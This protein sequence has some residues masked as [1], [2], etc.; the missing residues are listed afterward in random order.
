MKNLKTT[1]ALFIA[2]TSLAGCKPEHDKDWYK[3]H[4]AERKQ[5][6]SDCEKNAESLQDA[7]C[8]NA[9]EAQSELYL[10][11]KNNS[12]SVPKLN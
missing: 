4:E 12:H 10:Y 9:K 8:K 7:D 11:G 5:M 3:S 1:F 2:I 6:I